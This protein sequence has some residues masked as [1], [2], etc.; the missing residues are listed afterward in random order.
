LTGTILLTVPL[1]CLGFSLLFLI[2]PPGQAPPAGPA[3]GDVAGVQATAAPAEATTPPAAAVDTSAPEPPATEPPAPAETPTT[4]ATATATA[5]V[6]TAVRATEPIAS[7]TPP[8]PPDPAQPT[9]LVPT[10]RQIDTV[11]ILRAEM[12]PGRS[13]LRVEATSSGDGAE[14]TVFVTATG[15]KIGTLERGEGDTYRGEFF[16]TRAIDLITVVSSLGGQ[17]TATVKQ[18]GGGG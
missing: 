7:E 1:Y 16:W 13:E 9:A 2:P 17:A 5:P 8:S 12:R 6:P 4:E 11:T 18:A 14:L 15:V 3:G 10:P